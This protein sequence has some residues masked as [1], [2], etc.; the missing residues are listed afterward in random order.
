MNDLDI[1]ALIEKRQ[2]KHD[3]L[4]TLL[5]D[6]EGGKL[7]PV[8]PIFHRK[9]KE[10]T[11][12]EDI[13]SGEYVKI[14]GEIDEIKGPFEFR[15]Q[16]ASS[17]KV[18]FIELMVLLDKV[19]L[20]LWD[21]NCEVSKQL[22]EGNEI[23]VEGSVKEYRG[24]PQVHVKSLIIHKT[25]MKS[26]SRREA[27]KVIDIDDVKSGEYV[28]I[29]GE[30]DGIGHPFKFG[31]KNGEVGKGVRIEVMGPLDTFEFK[32]WNDDYELSEQL[33]EGDKIE[34]EGVLR[35]YTYKKI[36]RMELKYIKSLTLHKKLL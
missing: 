8:K 7:I 30:I 18:V 27:K 21:D 20:V 4:R 26:I 13:K 36:D 2:R 16:D 15:R 1:D 12:I 3:E 24:E 6:I 32:L 17:G 10:V 22:A 14:I 31:R 29:S 35:K 23:E 11:E 9:A 25:L 33:T 19:E 28:N 34:L 5:K